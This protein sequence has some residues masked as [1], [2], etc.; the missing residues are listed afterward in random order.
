[1]NQFAREDSQPLE[2]CDCGPFEAPGHGK[3]PILVNKKDLDP[4]W[5]A[6]DDGE[7]RKVLGKEFIFAHPIE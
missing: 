7:C 5:V 4:V 6:V 3:G 2:V 1:M